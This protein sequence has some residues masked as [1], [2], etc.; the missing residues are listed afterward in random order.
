MT[1]QK[2]DRIS[3]IFFYQAPIIN[4]K[5]PEYKSHAILAD[6]GDVYIF[7]TLV[8]LTPLKTRMVEGDARVIDNASEHL[9]TSHTSHKDPPD[10]FV[11]NN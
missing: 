9:P 5:T 11:G 2:L 3:D 10:D 1:N 7:D 4:P 6:H 8:Y